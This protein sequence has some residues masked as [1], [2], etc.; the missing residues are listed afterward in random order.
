MIGEETGKAS[1]QPSGLSSRLQ[2]QEPPQ[3][4]HSH[5]LPIE[6]LDQVIAGQGRSSCHDG[7]PRTGPWTSNSGG[8]RALDGRG[9]TAPRIFFVISKEK[10]R[11]PRPS[12]NKTTNAR[13]QLPA[14]EL[15]NVLITSRSNLRF[16]WKADDLRLIE[17]D[18]V[19]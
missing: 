13:A 12:R 11:K 9:S 7:P 6:V 4:A 3:P 1:P 8:I 14:V 15:L 10:E 16:D 2:D 19:Q 18:L 17:K 5:G